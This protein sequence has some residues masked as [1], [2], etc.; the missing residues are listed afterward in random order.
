MDTMEAETATLYDLLGRHWTVRAPVT[1]TAFAGDAVAFA[2]TDGALAIAPL[3]DIERPQDRCRIALDGGRAT[4]SPRRKPVPPLTKV[5]ISDAPLHLASIGSSGFVANERS[6]LLG[7]SPSGVTHLIADHGS[8][9]DLV[10]P[11]QAGGILAAS[12]GSVIFYDPNGEVGWLQERAGRNA[13]ALAVSSDGRRFAM[14]VDD[15]V[16]VRA[17]GARP[18]PVASFEL[19]PIS[20]LAW[21]PDGSWLAASIVGT[22]VVLVRLAD[23]RIV[24]ISSYPGNNSSLAWSTDSRVLVTSGAYRIIAWDISSLSDDSERPASLSTGHARPVLVDAIDIHPE[25]QLIAAG[26]RDGMVVVAKMGESDEL[27]VKPPGGGAVHA[28]RWSADGQ[29]LAF[30]SDNGEA[31]IITFPSHIFK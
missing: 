2:L 6:R 15:C 3:T 20:N 8:A 31:A 23:A 30:G 13:S 24:R 4:I 22:G 7:V 1:S 14:G 5:V 10:A 17:F 9:I 21:S 27:V 25:G 18:E 26:Y 12:G 16:L 29:H 11:V 28:L 19:G